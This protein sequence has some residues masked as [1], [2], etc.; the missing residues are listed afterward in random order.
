MR[1]RSKRRY[2]VFKLS[3]SHLNEREVRKLIVA[4]VLKYYGLKGYGDSLPRLA[5]FDRERVAGVIACLKEGV[6]VIR[7]SLALISKYKGK[8]VRLE[9]LKIT[10]TLRKAIRIVR[11]L[12]PTGS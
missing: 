6:D 7:S 3:G 4:S 2:L 9:T 10:G 5:Y 8:E 11:S 12:T 1:G